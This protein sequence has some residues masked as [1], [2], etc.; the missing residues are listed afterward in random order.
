MILTIKASGTAPSEVVATLLERMGQY[1]KHV[2][3]NYFQAI[4]FLERALAIV[5]GGDEP[6][7]PII[8]RILSNLGTTLFASAKAGSAVT[9]LV[10][11]WA[12]LSDA[13]KAVKCLGQ[14]LAIKDQSYHMDH[15][16]KILTLKDLAIAWHLLENLDKSMRFLELLLISYFRSA[17]SVMLFE[18]S[19]KM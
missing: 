6:N 13:H 7:Y 1:Y 4:S 2:K 14:A 18:K 19:T 8:A 9:N 3:G 16:E 5:R 11:I 10:A 12:G 17:A 15:P